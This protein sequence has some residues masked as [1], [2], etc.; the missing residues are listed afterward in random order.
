VR[1]DAGVGVRRASPDGV[2]IMRS[3][4]PISSG[5][6]SAAGCARAHA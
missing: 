2:R 3:P 5:P 4:M 6:I 1:K